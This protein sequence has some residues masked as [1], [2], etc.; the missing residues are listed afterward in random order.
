[1]RHSKYNPKYDPKHSSNRHETAALVMPAP[2]VTPAVDTQPVQATAAPQIATKSHEQVVMD[3][4]HQEM[5]SDSQDAPVAKEV[6][7]PISDKD[8]DAPISDSRQPAADKN[9]PAVR[10]PSALT[11]GLPELPVTKA[12]PETDENTPDLSDKTSA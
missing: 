7:A 11:G 8:M 5:K 9:V 3:G 2:A 10:E 12:S 4:N 6:D 1:M